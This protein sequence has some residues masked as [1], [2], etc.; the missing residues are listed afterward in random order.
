MTFVILGLGS[1]LKDRKENLL[2]SINLVNNLPE[3]VLVAQSD[4]YD[5]KAVLPLNAPKSWN[6]N[7]LNMAIK[8]KTTLSAFDL[9]KEI[10]IIE[11]LLGR[12][13]NKKW[14]PRII[15]IDILAYGDQII[16]SDLLTVPHR[17]LLIRDFALKPFVQIW[18]EWKYPVTGLDYGK[19][20]CELI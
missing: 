8:I 9:L 19:K 11:K 20:I 3:V 17:D 16:N 14:S 7:Y 10:K 4:I 2:K 5:N 13:N 6:K 12:K 15:D 1:N 18:P